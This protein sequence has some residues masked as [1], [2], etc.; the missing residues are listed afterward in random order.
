MILITKKVRRAPHDIVALCGR[1]L[2]RHRH[3][4]VDLQGLENAPIY[5]VTMRNCSFGTIKNPSI[6]KNVKG[7]KLNNV[8]VAGGLVDKLA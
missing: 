8:K 7:L 3:R 6:V 4:A 2:L 1:R 5:D